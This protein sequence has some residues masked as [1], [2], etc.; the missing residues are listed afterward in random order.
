M[1]ALAMSDYLENK[2][3]DHCLRAQAH[4]PTANV[5]LAV[6]S[7]ATSDTALGTEATGS[8]YARP[9]ITFGAP[10]LGVA[11]NSVLASS[12][13]PVGT[14][15]HAA[16]M[17]ASTGGNILFHGPLSTTRTTTL[18]QTVAF[19]VGEIVVSF[20][21]ASN[22]TDYLRNLIINRFLRNQAFTP[23]TIYAGLYTTATDRTG[24]GTEVTGGAYGRVAITLSAGAAGVTANTNLVSITVP[25]T[26]VTHMAIL[27]AVSAGNMLLQSALTGGAQVTGSGDLVRFPIGDYDLVVT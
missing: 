9:A 16:I 6:C 5:Y 11:S 17:D 13:F 3:I 4:T 23:G 20:T 10:S 1:T 25:A 12:T 26:T 19:S 14:W 18:G 22:A 24:A 8:G 2:V 7:T 27:N 15:T 21:T